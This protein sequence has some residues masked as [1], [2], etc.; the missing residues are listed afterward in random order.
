MPET[1]EAE[2]V[3]FLEGLVRRPVVIRH[4]VGGDENAGA[5]IAESTVDKNFFV[6]ILE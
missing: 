3:H 2:K 6:V 4:A 1:V 5:I